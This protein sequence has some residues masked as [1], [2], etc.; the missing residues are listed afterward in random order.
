MDRM[1]QSIRDENDTP[2][3]LSELQLGDYLEA[4]QRSLHQPLDP[5]PSDAR[6]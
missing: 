1:Q 5:G 4:D 3:T 6:S 2:L